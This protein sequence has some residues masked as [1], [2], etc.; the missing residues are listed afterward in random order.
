VLQV[1]GADG[2]S[3]PLWWR[4]RRPGD[5]LRPAGRGGSKKLKAW[6]IDEKVPR[7]SRDLLWLLADDEGR[8]LWIPALGVRS[9]KPSVSARLRP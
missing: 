7:E 3:W 6:L 2:A 5:R 9:E 1:D 4:V 8:V